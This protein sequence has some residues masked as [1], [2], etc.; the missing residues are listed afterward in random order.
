MLATPR[1][2]FWIKFQ[3]W[4]TPNW[5]AC[6]LT[7]TR[8]SN[9]S[10]L[11]RPDITVMVDWALKINYIYLSPLLPAIVCFCLLTDCT[12]LFPCLWTDQA[13]KEKLKVKLSAYGEREGCY[14]YC[15]RCICMCQCIFGIGRPG[16]CGFVWGM[17]MGCLFCLSKIR[18][19][20]FC[21]FVFVPP[22]EL[23]GSPRAGWDF[24]CAALFSC[25]CVNTWTLLCLPS[26][27]Q[28]H[29]DFRGLSLVCLAWRWWY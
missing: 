3:C 24:A 16:F 20:S 23:G 26:F 14:C 18:K 4:K 21:L 19:K 28:L 9:V 22:H 5:H 1:W 29:A 15:Y 12:E 10:R 25:T 7:L 6:T 8:L 27:R 2:R 17:C 11:L 13:F